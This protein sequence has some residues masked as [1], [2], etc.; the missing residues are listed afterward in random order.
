MVAGSAENWIAGFAGAG[1]G[2]STFGGGGGGGGGTF[3]L[4][5]AANSIKETASNTALIFRLFILRLPPRAS[6][7]IFP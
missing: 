3:F 2:A 1:A 7:G 6:T 4:Q 5:P